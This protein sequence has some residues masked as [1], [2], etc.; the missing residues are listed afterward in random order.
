MMM[1]LRLEGFTEG[2]LNEVVRMG[3]ASNKSEAIRI[4]ILHYNE[5]FGIKPISKQV[6]MAALKRKI[7]QIDAEVAAG[8]RK[9]ISEEE[10]LARHP[11][12]KKYLK[13]G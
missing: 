3:I 12:L 10:F 9:M 4:M 11:E 6:E 2:V 5:H 13:D 8:K 7:D 1:N